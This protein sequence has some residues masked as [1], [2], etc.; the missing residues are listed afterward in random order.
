M[1]LSLT[2]LAYAE[3][4]KYTE[5]KKSK[6]SYRKLLW[7]YG[8]THVEKGESVLTGLSGYFEQ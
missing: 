4:P 2:K 8:L 1:R 5:L 3:M 7:A 6:N